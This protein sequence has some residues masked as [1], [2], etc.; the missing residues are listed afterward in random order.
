MNMSEHKEQLS[1]HKEQFSEHKEQL[2]EHTKFAYFRVNDLRTMV[3][4]S[5]TEINYSISRFDSDF[6]KL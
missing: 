5:V 4:P 2:S 3:K 1:E 6:V